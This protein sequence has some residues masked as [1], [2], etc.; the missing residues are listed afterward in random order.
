M[1]LSD[2]QQIEYI[3]GVDGAYID[4]AFAPTRFKMYHAVVSFNTD[5]TQTSSYITGVSDGNSHYYNYRFSYSDNKYHWR[6]GSYTDQSFGPVFA[7]DAKLLMDMSHTGNSTTLVYTNVETE[8]SVSKQISWPSSSVTSTEDAY[9]LAMNNN[10]TASSFGV[11]HRIYSFKVFETNPDSPQYDTYIRDFVPVR[12]KTGLTPKVGMYDV[13]ND[14]IYWSASA[15]NFVAGPDVGGGGGVQIYVKVGGT[16]KLG[17]PYIK[18]N[19]NWEPADNVY[20]KTG[21]NWEPAA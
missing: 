6:F 19:G 14:V 3:E 10:G 21:G 7:K 1:A 12:E 9:L 11:G 17:D 16:W 15:T 5:N 18:V 20:I 2:Y 4:M 8:Q 13:V